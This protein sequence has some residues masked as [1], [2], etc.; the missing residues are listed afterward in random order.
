VWQGQTIDYRLTRAI[1]EVALTIRGKELAAELE[2]IRQDT[3]IND[4]LRKLVS[5]YK[6]HHHR[7]G[8][9]DAWEGLLEVAGLGAGAGAG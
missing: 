2:A 9:S 1:V 3:S 8:G 7:G 5:T 6:H 4:D